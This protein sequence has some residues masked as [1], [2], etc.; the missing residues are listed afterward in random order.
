MKGSAV[1]NDQPCVIG[2][3]SANRRAV[4]QI[5]NDRHNR[6]FYS[7]MFLMGDIIDLAI[8]IEKNA[9]TVYRKALL[10]MTN[11]SLVSILQW[12][13]DEEV[14][15][16]EWF[17][18]L[19]KT[20]DPQVK[21]PA[22]EAMG[23]S[24]LSDVLGKQSFSLREADFGKINRLED[25]LLLAIEFEKDKVVFYKMLRPFIAEN[26]TLDFLENIIEEES[27]HIRE[28]RK[29]VNRGV[30]RGKINSEA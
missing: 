29:L 27:H 8:Q 15:H 13:A 22:V 11:P 5:K 23:K 21:D 10:K 14:E 25:L 20:I 18:Q 19:K 9:E 4:A 12:L 28:L 7:H 26:E 2:M 30:D 24:L 3:G 17:R 6:R 16:A 1:S